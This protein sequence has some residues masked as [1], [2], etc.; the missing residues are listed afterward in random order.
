ML[1]HTT[2]VCMWCPNIMQSTEEASWQLRLLWKSPLEWHNSGSPP[3]REQYAVWGLMLLGGGGFI[4]PC[5]AVADFVPAEVSTASLCSFRI[6]FL[7]PYFFLC[8]VSKLFPKSPKW[9][10]RNCSSNLSC[11][12]SHSHSGRNGN[13][14]RRGESHPSFGDH[15]LLDSWQNS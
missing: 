14:K 7:T 12:S 9:E 13:S 15:E 10:L 5:L 6:I 8:K 3:V 4:D 1:Q 11:L 2:V